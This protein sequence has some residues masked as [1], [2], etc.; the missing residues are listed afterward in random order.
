MTRA[1]CSGDYS[2]DEIKF[3]DRYFLGPDPFLEPRTF[4]LSEDEGDHSFVGE[5]NSIPSTV[6]GGGIHAD[7]KVPRFLEEDFT[8]L[9]TYGPQEDAAV[10]DWPLD[11]AELEPYYADVE[12]RIG[13]SGLAGANPFAP[14]RSGPFPM[15]PGPSMYGATLSAAA[16]E[17]L[18]FHPYPAPSAIN[19]VPYDARPAC[20]NCGFCAYFACP[21][22]AKGDPV[23][24]LQRALLSGNAELRPETFVLAHPHRRPPGDRSGFHRARRGRAVHGRPLRGGGRWCGRDAPPLIP[25]RLRPSAHRSPLD[26]PLPDHRGRRRSPPVSVSTVSGAGR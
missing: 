4:R 7:G 6:G 24:M 25:V 10:A 5:V 2:N 18:G 21:I 8:M 26:D 23:A 11:Y 20:N 16:A 17:S 9:S 15:P 19:S 22:H 12:R 14:W 3:I 1:G 13:V